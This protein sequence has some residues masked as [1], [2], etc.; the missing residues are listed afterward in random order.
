V[1]LWDGKTGAIDRDVAEHWKKYDLKRILTQNWATLGPKLAG[2]KVH[3][4]VGDADDYFLN[5][6]V[7][8]LK[9][10]LE[11]LTNPRF[12]GTITIQPGMGHTNGGWTRRQMLDAMARR[13]G[14]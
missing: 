10:E 13:A 3:V 14:V 5:M 2:G 11:R 12:D 8:L 1:P 6:A 9:P 7:R 4:W